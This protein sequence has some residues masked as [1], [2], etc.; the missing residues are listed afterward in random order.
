MLHRNLISHRISPDPPNRPKRV[1]PGRAAFVEPKTTRREVG[2]L[3]E[4]VHAL[5]ELFPCFFGW[6]SR[7]PWI[8][9]A[10]MAD[11][12]RRPGCMRR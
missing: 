3:P 7:V 8:R 11:G 5:K 4:M 10:R 6:A 12:P 9:S 2:V 1:V